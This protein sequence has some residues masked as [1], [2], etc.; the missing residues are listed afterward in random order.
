MHSFCPCCPH[1]ATQWAWL[2]E[3]TLL[4]HRQLEYLCYHLYLTELSA[5]FTDDFTTLYILAANT[6]W[7]TVSSFF[8]YLQNNKI[9]MSE[10]QVNSKWLWLFSVFET[11]DSWFDSSGLH[12]EASLGKILNPKLPLTLH[13][14]HRHQCM[15]RCNVLLIKHLLSALKCKCKMC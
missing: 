11:L 2:V 7:K 8:F 15:N 14:R 1:Q 10:S 9:H 3:C 13:G 4:S 6:I 12:V 5:K